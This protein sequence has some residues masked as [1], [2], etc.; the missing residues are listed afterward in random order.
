MPRGKPEKYL[1][2]A[3]GIV[4]LINRQRI[5]RGQMLPP[6]RK[7]AELFAC[8]QLTVRKALRK[9]EQENLIYKVPSVG[10]FA[11]PPPEADDGPGLVGIIFPD[12][13]LY[14]YRILLKLERIFET[15]N[16]YPIVKLT[17]HTAAREDEIIDFFRSRSVRAVIAVPNALCAGR[18]EA[19]RCPVIFF[20]L[21]IEK[22]AIPYVISD[23][24]AG[25]EAAVEYLHSIGHRRIAY[26]GSAF[27]PASQ[28]RLEGYYNILARHGIAVNRKYVRVKAMSREWG[29]QSAR[30]LLALPEPPTAFFCGNDTV[31]AGA[32]RFCV[33]SGR[34]VPG[35]VSIV[36]FGNTEI[37]EDLFLTSV[38]QHSDKIA[39]VL[40]ENLRLLSAGYKIPRC[41]VTPTTLVVRRSTGAAR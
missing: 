15:L 37:A 35:D 32:M 1:G 22:C 3:A 20:D 8:S 40:S 29:F 33:E 41:T 7:L 27:D 36:G 23:D 6:E 21:S 16:L 14:Y 10:N 30:E 24:L 2:I 25:A 5:Q 38:S 9:L 11:G 39:A 28:S 31:A 26:L 17:H 12:D 34:R 13:E 4:E 19:L 18:Y